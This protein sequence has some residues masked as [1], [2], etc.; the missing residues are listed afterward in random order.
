MDNVIEKNWN[1]D[2]RSYPVVFGHK[3]KRNGE[4]EPLNPNLE[5][6]VHLFMDYVRHFGR[7]YAVDHFFRMEEHFK[8]L[9]RKDLEPECMIEWVRKVERDEYD[10]DNAVYSVPPRR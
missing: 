10:F 9:G 4:I 3:R 1:G 8:R 6:S 7:Q 2:E 5:V